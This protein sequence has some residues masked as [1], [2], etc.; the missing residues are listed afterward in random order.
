[1]AVSHRAVVRLVRECG[2]AQVGVGD[3]VA[4]G[5]SVS[6]DAATFEVWGALV[7]GAAVAVAPA[8]VLS[9]AELGGFVSRAGVTV[10]WL[11]AGLFHQ[12]AEVDVGVFAGLRWLLAGGDV[13]GVGQ[14]RVVL[15]GVPSVRLVNGYG[16]TEN[17]TFTATHRVRTS[18]VQGGGPVPV[19]RPVAGTRVFVL[20]GW[21]C[22]VPVGVAGELYAAGAGL[23][24]GYAGQGG[25]TAERFVACPFGTGGQRM[26]RTG[27]LARWTPDGVLV[28]AGRADDQVKIRGFRIEP[29]EVEAVLADC[30][31]VA[32]AVVTVREDTPGERRLAGYVVPAGTR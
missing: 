21:L 8:G 28:F 31:G 18:D 24:R 19:G 3:V 16:P 1:M 7:N 5:S 26:Y 9:V 12:V 29:G 14:C 15:E 25:L 11:T 13:L 2:F 6:F 10:L 17:T 23:A 20:D 22:P 30:P 4:L 32:Q 27:D